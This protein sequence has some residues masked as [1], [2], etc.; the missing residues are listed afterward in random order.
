MRK[1]LQ[2]SVFLSAT[3]KGNSAPLVDDVIMGG[4]A[5]KNLQPP[6]RKPFSPPPEEKV[7]EGRGRWTTVI[8]CGGFLLGGSLRISLGDLNWP[9]GIL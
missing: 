9:E 8:K 7:G 4:G 6:P 5:V 3:V 2:L 1:L